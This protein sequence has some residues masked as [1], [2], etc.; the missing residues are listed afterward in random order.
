MLADAG[1]GRGLGHVVR[2]V[3]L[4]QAL[5]DRECDVTVRTDDDPSARRIVT[6]AGLRWAP[7]VEGSA[8]F[9]VVIVDSYVRTVA[10][11]RRLLGPHG[12][13][14]EIADAGRTQTEA[15]IVIAP[16]PGSEA[17]AF[18]GP[19]L[20]ATF[21]GAEHALVPAA[22]RPGRGPRAGTVISLGGGGPSELVAATLRTTGLPQPVH[23]VIGPYGAMPEGS[24]ATV[25][26]DLLPSAVAALFN[27]ASI[28]ILSAGQTLLQAAACGLPPIAV[29]T[30]DNQMTQARAMQSAGATM[31]VVDARSDDISQE[32]EAALQRGDADRVGRRA[33]GIIDGAGS[34]RVADGILRT[35]GST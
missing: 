34:S 13:L 4:A 7:W 26:V 3:A 24:P 22:F 1:P 19:S 6:T 27:Q 10:D 30:A 32:L 29:I 35:L 8:T 28:G 14:V 23:A 9:D 20:R 25:H 15:D 21:A 5:A 12:V 18:S 31:G 11:V 16:W 17:S 2:S 33:A